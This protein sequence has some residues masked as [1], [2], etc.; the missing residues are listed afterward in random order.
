MSNYNN[1]DLHS[2]RLKLSQQHYYPHN[3]NCSLQVQAEKDSENI[4]FYFKQFDIRPAFPLQYCQYDW[5]ELHDGNSTD[6][7]YI[8]GRFFLVNRN[9]QSV[10]SVSSQLAFFINLQRAVIGPSATLTGR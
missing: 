2:F 1:V 4:M 6:S 9:R 7:Q 5:L 8:C 10:K 3:L